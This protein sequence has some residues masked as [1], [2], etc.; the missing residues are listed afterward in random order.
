MTTSILPGPRDLFTF[1]DYKAHEAKVDEWAAQEI[2]VAFKECP[3]NYETRLSRP[4]FMTVRDMEG[5]VQRLK[6]QKWVVRLDKDSILIERPQCAEEFLHPNRELKRHE[7]ARVLNCD[8][9]D[10]VWASRNGMWTTTDA[11]SQLEWELDPY[12]E[13]IHVRDGMGTNHSWRGERLAG[14]PGG[15]ERLMEIREDLQQEMGELHWE[16]F[17]R[18]FESMGQESLVETGFVPEAL[19]ELHEALDVAE[20][21]LNGPRVDLRLTQADAAEIL[22]LPKSALYFEDQDEVWLEDADMYDWAL[23][24]DGTHLN[25]TSGAYTFRWEG[26][27]QSKQELIQVREALEAALSGLTTAPAR[28]SET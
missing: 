6:D 24:E 27:P 20:R 18:V 19:E 22:D 11:C 28:P 13:R 26:K 8:P 3:Y 4:G 2:R 16:A 25:V 12:G 15:V 7:V 23:A 17:R 1:I 9:G 5:L 21:E 14:Q 10:A